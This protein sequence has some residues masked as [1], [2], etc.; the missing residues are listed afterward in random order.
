M[1]GDRDASYDH[2]AYKEYYLIYPPLTQIGL[3]ASGWIAGALF[4]GSS[5]AESIVWKFLLI[6]AETATMLLLARILALM[7]RSRK[8]LLLYAWHPLP[9]LEFAGQGHADALM[10]AFLMAAL[11]CVMR[12]K[13]PLASVFFAAAVAARGCARFCTFVFAA[14][15]GETLCRFSRI[16][17]VRIRAVLFAGGDARDILFTS[18]MA[19]FFTFNSCGYWAIRMVF[20]CNDN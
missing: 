13:E 17:G 4:D 14:C 6:L 18:Q 15:F 7:R 5:K 16:N 20:N 1:S 8:Y 9:I 3:G 10:I 11:Y 19:Q 2:I 12:G